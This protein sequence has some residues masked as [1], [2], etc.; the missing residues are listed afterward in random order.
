M[1]YC[2][3]CGAQIAEHAP[4][5]SQ[6]GA[7]QKAA[8]ALPV[9][10]A[11]AA[12]SSRLTEN[13]AATLSYAFLWV[14]GLIFLL[15]D[16]RPFVRFHAAQSIVIFLGLHIVHWALAAFWGLR[17]LHDGWNSF[18]PGFALFHAVDIL[19]FVLWV[20][21]MIKAYQGEWF[22]VPI[23]W[24]VAEGFGAKVPADKR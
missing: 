23:V 24:E 12:Q 11:G 16:K 5:C 9:A 13:V 3:K 22:K 21:L 2:D 6:C 18:A 19:T 20:V 1:A 4:Y 14:G 17:L 15:I 10:G 7:Q 8:T